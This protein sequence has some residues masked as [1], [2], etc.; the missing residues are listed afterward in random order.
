[1]GLI[2]EQVVFHGQSYGKQKQIINWYAKC[3]ENLSSANICY[4][5]HKHL[6]ASARIFPWHH[7]TNTIIKC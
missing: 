2:E 3:K 5:L 4:R 7:V 1:M 6:I